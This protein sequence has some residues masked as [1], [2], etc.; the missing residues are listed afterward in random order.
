MKDNRVTTLHFSPFA[1]PQMY[2]E[3]LY[4]AERDQHFPPLF[5]PNSISRTNFCL[6]LP[7]GAEQKE[8][9][10]GLFVV[11]PPSPPHPLQSPPI[12]LLYYL[13]DVCRWQKIISQIKKPRTNLAAAP[14][15]GWPEPCPGSS[16]A[17]VSDREEGRRACAEE[18]VT[19]MKPPALHPLVKST[20]TS[21]ITPL[22]GSGGWKGAGGGGGSEKPGCLSVHPPAPTHPSTPPTPH[23]HFC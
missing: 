7:L 3:A 19:P 17:K 21:P 9:V 1:A 5:F 2:S 8:Q 14:E 4:L 20:H 6:L 16:R 18:R 10:L 22:R 12:G 11:T 13:A 23:L 15:T